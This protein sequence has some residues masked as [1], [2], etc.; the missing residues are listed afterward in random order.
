MNSH[1]ETEA[2]TYRYVRERIKGGNIIKHCLPNIWD[3]GGL[4]R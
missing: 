1:I 4:D 2:Q 3:E